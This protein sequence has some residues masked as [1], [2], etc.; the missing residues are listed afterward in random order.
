MYRS[1]RG[2]R[3]VKRMLVKWFEISGRKS[4]FSISFRRL[5]T[6]P[7]S[8]GQ[9]HSN[10]KT[11]RRMQHTFWINSVNPLST[12]LL[13]AARISILVICSSTGNTE[14]WT[15]A[16]MAISTTLVIFLISSV[17]INFRI[18][19]YRL[20]YSA[21]SWMHA[22]SILWS[23]KK[24]NPRSTFKTLQKAH[25]PLMLVIHLLPN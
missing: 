7:T 11:R 22:F 12:C 20:K 14:F 9:N 1:M 8:Q 13:R 18:F 15:L 23:G 10:K 24:S 25:Q 5:Y 3:F 17:D 2:F 16:L 19:S 21:C 6:H 4:S